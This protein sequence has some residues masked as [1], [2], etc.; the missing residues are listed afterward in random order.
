MTDD[1]NKLA[2]FSNEELGDELIRRGV[3]KRLPTLVCFEDDEGDIR[4]R[5]SHRTACFGLA[6]WFLRTTEKFW[7][8]V[9]E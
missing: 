5:C 8:E 3:E 4:S 2:L 1:E 9:E 7:D 6:S